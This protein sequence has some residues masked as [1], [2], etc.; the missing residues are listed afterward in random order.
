MECYFVEGTVLSVLY[1]ISYIIILGGIIFSKWRMSGQSEV[2]KHFQGHT[3]SK[4]MSVKPT[5]INPNP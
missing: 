2:T 1:L 4:S 5:A 3:G